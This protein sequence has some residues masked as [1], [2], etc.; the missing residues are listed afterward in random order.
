[1][2]ESSD[3][4]VNFQEEGRVIRG[5]GISQALRCGGAGGASC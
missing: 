4:A 3:M 5:G 1:M 2:L